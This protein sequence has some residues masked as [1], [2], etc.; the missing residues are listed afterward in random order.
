MAATAI[1]ASCYQLASIPVPGGLFFEYGSLFIHIIKVGTD[2]GSKMLV[3][4]LGVACGAK[5]FEYFTSKMCFFVFLRSR[6]IQNRFFLVKM[7]QNEI[8]NVFRG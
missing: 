6:D 2:E 3:F 8:F 1:R 4:F 7:M 5:R